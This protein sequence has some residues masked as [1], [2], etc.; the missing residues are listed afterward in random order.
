MD[1]RGPRRGV[2]F[3]G[4]GAVSPP[5]HQ[6]GVWGSAVSSPSGIGAGRIL[7]VEGHGGGSNY[8]GT[9]RRKKIL[10]PPH[11]SVVPTQFLM[12]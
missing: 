9:K 1:E 12:E 3:L 4:R 6:L 5:P 10:V 7:K 2:G 8:F 11:F